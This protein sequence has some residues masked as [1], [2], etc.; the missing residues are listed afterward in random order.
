MLDLALLAEYIR[1]N[2]NVPV[3]GEGNQLIL[4]LT[5]SNGRSQ[6]VLISIRNF[7]SD[8]II[9]V[10]SRCG[11]ITNPKSVRASLKRNYSG[12]VGGLCMDKVDGQHIIDCVQRLVVPPGL[13]VN[14]EEF[15][16]TIS[17]IGLQ[18]DL[19][20]SNLSNTDVF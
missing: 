13:G 3:I 2:L 19:I 20:E 17:S 5:L 8:K 10:R 15:L 16:I 14:I 1:V 12:S 11:V 18:A 9:E 4:S 6:A 7:K